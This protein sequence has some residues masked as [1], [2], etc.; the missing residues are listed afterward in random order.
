M[1]SL[2]S[3]SASS[4]NT[5]G[6]GNIEL[7]KQTRLQIYSL[8]AKVAKSGKTRVGFYKYVTERAYWSDRIRI[9]VMPPGCCYTM[10]FDEGNESLV[11]VA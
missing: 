1:G 5:D 3:W 9:C 10:R 11:Y 6:A 2:R 7:K 4:F 8:G